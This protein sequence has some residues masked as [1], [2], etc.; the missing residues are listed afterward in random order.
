MKLELLDAGGAVVAGHVY[1]GK[2]IIGSFNRGRLPQTGHRELP[3][4]GGMQRVDLAQKIGADRRFSA[5]A[6]R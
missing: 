3:S 1:F 4:A 5:L 6:V 2:G